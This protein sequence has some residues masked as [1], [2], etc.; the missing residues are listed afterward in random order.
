MQGW[1]VQGNL[2]SGCPPDTSSSDAFCGLGLV[3][4][5]GLGCAKIRVHRAS[6][7]CISQGRGLGW[8]G[9]GL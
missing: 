3:T 7:V 5:E 6:D 9:G 1:R 2:P 4:Q 8:G